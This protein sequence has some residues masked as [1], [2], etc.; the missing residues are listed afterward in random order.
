MFES[1]VKDTKRPR[2]TLLTRIR[3]FRVLLGV[4]AFGA[5]G[6]LIPLYNQFFGDG[7]LELVVDGGRQI[8]LSIDGRA[9]QAAQ[10]FGVHQRFFV[11]P[12]DHTIRVRDVRSGQVM[13]ERPI[14]LESPSTHLVIPLDGAQCFAHVNYTDHLRHLAYGTSIDRPPYVARRF[15]GAPFELP[16]WTYLAPE[17]LPTRP[18]PMDM[19]FLL[20]PVDCAGPDPSE[21]E[22]LRRA[23]L[24]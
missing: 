18:Q 20:I 15:E 23:G 16:I 4:A 8:E 5:F 13:S 1:I 21:A 24:R 2:P 12:G 7:K 22:A 6:L 10:T 9:A 19:A 11:K 3:Q 14:R 17:E